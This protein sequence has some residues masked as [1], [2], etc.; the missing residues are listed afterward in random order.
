MNI[1]QMTI[2]FN[3]LCDLE[4]GNKKNGKKRKNDDDNKTRSNR[5]RSGS[6]RAGNQ[7]NRYYSERNNGGEY[8]AVVANLVD[9]VAVAAVADKDVEAKED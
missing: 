9:K 7:K 3:G 1:A 4:G 5:Q 8:V 6:G 2:Y